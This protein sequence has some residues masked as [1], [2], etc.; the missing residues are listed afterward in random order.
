MNRFQ[1]IAL[2]M[3]AMTAGCS[4]LTA[5]NRENF[6]H[7]TEAPQSSVVLKKSDAVARPDFEPRSAFCAI[8]C[9]GNT[10]WDGEKNGW[11]ASYDL[12]DKVGVPLGEVH[13]GVK[14]GEKPSV[15]FNFH[16][17]VPPSSAAEVV[18]WT[19]TRFA[20]A[21]EGYRISAL[22]QENWGK[23]Y[24]DNPSSEGKATL[25]MT[26]DSITVLRK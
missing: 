22:V 10:V 8:Y 13:F 9:H 14:S 1:G 5:E 21:D 3:L 26:E 12:A 16:R 6:T 17:T 24:S 18:Q 4:H 23:K 7:R 11:K 20:G 2:L 25:S 19:V 15:V